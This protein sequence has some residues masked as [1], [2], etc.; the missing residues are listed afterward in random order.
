MAPLTPVYC[1]DRCLTSRRR[2]RLDNYLAAKVW[3]PTDRRRWA[4][5]RCSARTSCKASG[6]QR[7]A[8]FLPARGY[9]V[10]PADD[11]FTADEVALR[12]SIVPMESGGGGVR[13]LTKAP[14]RVLELTG[15]GNTEFPSAR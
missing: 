8:H 4:D 11:L 9:A 15:S 5:F 1:A 12:V 2:R 13:G 14:W 3:N 7:G 6:D 10:G